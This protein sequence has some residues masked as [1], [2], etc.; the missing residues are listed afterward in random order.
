MA[1]DP[2]LMATTPE[3]K[4]AD[5]FAGQRRAI[6][7]LQR[8]SVN[9]RLYVEDLSTVT[10]SGNWSYTLGPE[11]TIEVNAPGKWIRLWSTA[12]VRSTSTVSGANSVRYAVIH[13]ALDYPPGFLGGGANDGVL[14]ASDSSFGPLYPT[15]E[16]F[17]AES[18]GAGGLPRPP[19]PSVEYPASVGT[20]RLF[21]SYFAGAS[22]S[23]RQARN[24]RIWAEVF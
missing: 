24:R 13:D 11:L 16:N 22:D 12:Q 1:I 14:M 9:T 7:A 20:H 18:V 3:S 23:N 8:G 6:E 10:L 2:R 17:S 4:Q 15:V 21:M 5:R 19:I